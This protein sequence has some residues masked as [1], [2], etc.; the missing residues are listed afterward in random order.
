L[1]LQEFELYLLYTLPFVSFYSL[2]PMLTLYLKIGLELLNLFFSV[3]SR[4]KCVSW[5][6]SERVPNLIRVFLEG[7]LSTFQQGDKL[8]LKNESWKRFLSASS[9]NC[10]QK[11][12]VNP[13][14]IAQ[15]IAKF[16]IFALSFFLQ[17]SS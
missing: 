10:S 17:Y 16:T 1:D 8:M 13:I 14:K 9:D 2:R 12:G 3:L 15:K 11:L 5:T 6:R 4:P 7:S